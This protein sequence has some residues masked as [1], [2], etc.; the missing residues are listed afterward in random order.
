MILHEGGAMSLLRGVV[1]GG[2]RLITQQGQRMLSR[3]MEVAA[4]SCE[5]I[6]SRS[7]GMAVTGVVVGTGLVMAQAAFD[8]ELRELM[9]GKLKEL[10]GVNIDETT[11]DAVSNSSD[12]K[13]LMVRVNASETV[14][15]SALESNVKEIVMS[16]L[17]KP[18]M[19]GILGVGLGLAA[20]ALYESVKEALSDPKTKEQLEISIAALDN[21]I[22]HFE[23]ELEHQPSVAHQAN[24]DSFTF[25]APTH[26]ILP[27]DVQALKEERARLATNLDQVVKAENK[28]LSFS[29]LLPNLAKANIGPAPQGMTGYAK[30]ILSIKENINPT[31]PP[32]ASDQ[33]L[34]LMKT[35]QEMLE[36]SN[37]LDLVKKHNTLRQ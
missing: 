23:H 12:L 10:T 16:T 1:R 19:K 35:K 29:E 4:H 28:P 25:A 17:K 15:D 24:E 37:P 34:N 33:L 3:G 11:S 9:H 32:L 21:R 14:A 7:S 20:G 6:V 27:S 26:R 22:Q 8:T 5:A 31:L 18:Q 13:K 2:E 30:A 36:A